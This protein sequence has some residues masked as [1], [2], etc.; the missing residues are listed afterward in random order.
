MLQLKLSSSVVGEFL[1]KHLFSLENHQGACSRMKGTRGESEGGVW[2]RLGEAEDSAP[3][4]TLLVLS[5]AL[6]LGILKTFVDLSL[7]KSLPLRRK[8]EWSERDREGVG[9]G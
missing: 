1:L 3:R 6:L 2:V 9:D 7:H 8:E 4:L 5:A